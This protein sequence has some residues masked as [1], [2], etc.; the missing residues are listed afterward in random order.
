MKRLTA[1]EANLVTGGIDERSVDK[2]RFDHCIEYGMLSSV[3]F[4]LHTALG[5]NPVTGCIFIPVGFAI[6]FAIAYIAPDTKSHF[7]D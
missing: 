1:A 4:G 3:V 6:G 7:D 5:I 2:E